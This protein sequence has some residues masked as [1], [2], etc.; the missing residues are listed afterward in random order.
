MPRVAIRLAESAL[1][2]LDSVRDWYAEQGV[3]D[4][5]EGFL[6]EILDRVN[7]L[8]DHPEMG[9]VVPEFDQPTLRELLHPPFRIVYRLEKAKLFIVRVWRSER[10]LVKAIIV[11]NHVSI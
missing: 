3:P 4:I 8:R 5:G 6:S 10:L 7:S 2:D 11:E 9:R 1:A